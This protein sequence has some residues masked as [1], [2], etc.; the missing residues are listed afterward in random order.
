MIKR[1]LFLLL[2]ILAF[3]LSPIEILVW[4]FIW[5]FFGK[6]I[7]SY[8]LCLYMISD[9]FRLNDYWGD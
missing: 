4:V 6:D 1:L 3:F 9:D 7:P 2:S 8:P 5:I